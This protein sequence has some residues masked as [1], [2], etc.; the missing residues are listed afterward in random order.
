MRA[1]FL[2]QPL[3][4]CP[5]KAVGLLRPAFAVTRKP[6]AEKRSSLRCLLRLT[7]GAHPSRA[8]ARG[9]PSCLG[10]RGRKPFASLTVGDQSLRLFERSIKLS[11]LAR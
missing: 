10:R 8:V 11:D 1:L 5:P 7:V 2:D 4:P 3:A 6:A 9:S